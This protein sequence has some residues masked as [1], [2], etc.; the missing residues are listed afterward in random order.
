MVM[1]STVFALI[2]FMATSTGIMR[3]EPQSHAAIVT[4]AF[5]GDT[6]GM[7]GM[8]P[9]STPSNTFPVF[10][11]V[12]GAKRRIAVVGGTVAELLSRMNVELGELDEVD[13][14]LDARIHAGSVVTVTRR[15]YVTVTDTQ[16]IPY[17]TMYVYS[18]DLV[19]GTEQVRVQGEEGKRV[20]TVRRL[21][22][23]GEITEETVRSDNIQKE[24]VNAEILTG[25]PSKPT[26]PFDFESEFDENC[27][28]LCMRLSC[29]VKDPPP[30]AR[31][32]EP[33]QPAAVTR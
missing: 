23:N 1:L 13:M 8:V 15:E 6:G 30:T 14:P 3:E 2:V 19:P 9:D 27:E 29:A 32:P 21:L 11:E 26:S 16:A 31:A 25:F 10:V 33:E 12:D 7:A 18:P 22:V 17:E 4:L 28:P 5:A 20:R 24:P